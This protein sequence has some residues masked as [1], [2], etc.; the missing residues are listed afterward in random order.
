MLTKRATVAQTLQEDQRPEHYLPAN[1]ETGSSAVLLVESKSLENGNEIG[2]WGANNVLIGGGVANNDKTVITIWG[3]NSLTEEQKEGAVEGENLTL[4]IWNKATG[5]ES[6]TNVTGAQDALSGEKMPSQL[7]FKTNG[8]WI[9]QIEDPKQVP[10][11]Y[12]LEQNYPNPFNP[13][14]TIRYSIPKDGKVALEVYNLLGQKVVTLVDRE[15]KAGT[16]QTMFD[17][18]GLSSGVYVYI[19]R[20]GDYTATKKLVLLK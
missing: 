4:T 3:D 17:A 8:V 14:T 6:A 5:R 19:L 13:S 20:Q 1:S 9:A 15:Q 16:Y 2:V 12:S 18:H 10:T 7:A 11:V